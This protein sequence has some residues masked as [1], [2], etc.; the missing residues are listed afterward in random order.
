MQL[1]FFVLTFIF[2]FIL[3]PI[4]LVQK[5]RRERIAGSVICPK[6]GH[7]ATVYGDGS[8]PKCRAKFL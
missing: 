3:T 8:C 1:L 2:A 6:C 5:A 7:A 4:A